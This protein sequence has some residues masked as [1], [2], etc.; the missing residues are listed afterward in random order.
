MNKQELIQKIAKELHEKLGDPN[1]Q[2]NASSLSAES[3][4][5]EAAKIA[6]NCVIES[7][8]ITFSGNKKFLTTAT[9]AGDVIRTG[10]AI[11][12]SQSDRGYGGGS[13]SDG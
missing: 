6:F 9:S 12:N 1:Q 7:V 4:C 2:G 5:L 13:G 11:R 10:G 3:A 8:P